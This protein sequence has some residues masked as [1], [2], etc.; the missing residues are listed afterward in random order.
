MTTELAVHQDFLLPDTEDVHSG[1]RAIAR[2]RA[3]CRRELKEGSDY[4][5]IPGTQKPTLLKPGAEKLVGLLKL[6]DDYT[7]MDQIKD[8]DRPLFHFQLMASLRRLENGVVV[9]TGVGECNS[10]EARYRYRWVFQSDL[11]KLGLA[12]E[13]LF[14][15]QIATK[16]GRATQY[17]VDN[18]DIFSQVNT[19]LKMAKKRALVDAALRA[20]RLSDVFTQDL[21]DHGDEPEGRAAPARR[22]APAPPEK[23]TA[24]PE[25]TTAAHSELTTAERWEKRLIEGADDPRIAGMGVVELE[26][27][28]EGLGLSVARVAEILH[29][30]A[31]AVDAGLEEALTEGLGGADQV[32]Y[33]A[34][35]MAVVKAT[36][37]EAAADKVDYQ[38]LALA[39]TGEI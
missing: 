8:W 29:L 38:R 5:V 18:D 2:F 13:G 33:W 34:T 35:A 36:V 22:P 24:P 27:L 11:P 12:P 7:I 30:P 1:M 32:D 28:I 19:I 21:E 25:L 37:E 6:A 26:K 39:A 15:R 20:G 14:T 17:R 9:A 10:M 16:N 4:G 23:A 3:D 31:A